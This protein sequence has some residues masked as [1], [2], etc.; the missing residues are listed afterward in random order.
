[1]IIVILDGILERFA[2]GVL[3][4]SDFLLIGIDLLL[5]CLD[6]FVFCRPFRTQPIFC[7]FYVRIILRVRGIVLLPCLVPVICIDFS[8]AQPFIC[9][10]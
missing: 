9:S 6:L 2:L 10:F 1:M 3:P 5:S 4:V 8:A 7:S